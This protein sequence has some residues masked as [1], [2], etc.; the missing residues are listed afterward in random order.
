[1][2]DYLQISVEY[3]LKP[4]ERQQFLQNLLSQD[5]RSYF[6][7]RVVHHAQTF[8]QAVDMIKEEYIYPVR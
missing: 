1:M 7:E 8:E 2:K 3:D 5:A 4:Q 6:F